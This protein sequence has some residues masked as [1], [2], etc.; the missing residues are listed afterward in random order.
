MSD[1]NQPSYSQQP[2]Q[3]HDP[4][5]QPY[6]NPAGAVPYYS[7]PAGPQRPTSTI[8]LGIIGLLYAIY[9]TVCTCGGL[10]ITAAGGAFMD[11]AAV[12]MTPAQ[13]AQ[14][15]Q[16]MELDAWEIGSAVVSMAVGVLAWI[17][18]IGSFM[19]REIGRKALIWFS[20][21][22]LAMIPLGLIVE[23]VRG[24]PGIENARAQFAAQGTGGPPVGIFFAIGAVCAV[25]FL[26]YPICVLWFYTR[27][28]VKQWF[29]QNSAPAAQAQ[30]PGMY[31]QQ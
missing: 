11:Q 7:M 2:A 24:F 20:W 18:S 1:P 23:A 31:Y 19:G 5:A 29:Q 30:T 15:E 12:N 10:A 9:L 28:S 3:P 8:V 22:F 6:G 27:D 25:M 16:G 14:F 26:I 13:R 21:A 4:F 17:D